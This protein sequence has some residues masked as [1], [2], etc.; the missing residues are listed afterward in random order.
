MKGLALLAILA[1]ATTPVPASTAPCLTTAEAQS[2]TL[3]ALPAIIRQTGVVC[4]AALPST[5]IVRR[6]DS[7][8][9]VRYQAEGD[10]AWPAARSAIAK[11]SDPSIALLL[12]SDYA[13]PLLVSLLIPQLV[14]RIAVA[15]CPTIDRLVTLL[16]PLP[17]RN[18]A[19]II[20]ATLQYLKRAKAGGARIDAPD[21]PLCSGR[22]R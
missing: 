15:D 17:P 12:Q 13:R 7:P 11:L 10:R 21:L 4:A 20:V 22:E 5:S 2:V 16:A 19:G 14:G 6:T 18:T 8:L 1:Q 3:V 9:L